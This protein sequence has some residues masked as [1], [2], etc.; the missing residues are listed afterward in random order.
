MQQLLQ[1]V[2]EVC[3]LASR[4]GTPVG[5]AEATDGSRT[6]T[7]RRRCSCWR[8]ARWESRRRSATRTSTTRSSTV[9]C[10]PPWVFSL[11]FILAPRAGASAAERPRGAVSQHLRAADRAAAVGGQ[12]AGLARR[13]RHLHPALLAL[14]VAAAPGGAPQQRTGAVA[15]AGRQLAADARGHQSRAPRAAAAAARRAARAGRLDTVPAADAAVAAVDGDVAGTQGEGAADGADAAGLPGAA[16]QGGVGAA[17]AAPA[18]AERRDAVAV[19]AVAAAQ[20]G[21]G[22]RE[23][24]GAAGDC[25]GDDQAAGPDGCQRPAGA[26]GGAAR[27]PGEPQGGGDQDGAGDGP[28][29]D[30]GD[31]AAN[32]DVR[33]AAAGDGRAGERAAEGPSLHGA[34]DALGERDAGGQALLVALGDDEGDG[35]G[36]SGGGGGS[37]EG[38]ERRASVRHVEQEVQR[39]VGSRVFGEYVADSGVGV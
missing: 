26:T 19:G 11:R 39:R 12:P 14:A 9:C 37:P 7:A 16:V 24:E 28:Q 20:G 2:S 15:G 10:R 1:A 33:L 32:T 25:E 13:R 35:R 21:G 6:S 30:G 4:R 27:G 17:T 38:D 8:R 36:V 22:A 31:D 18:A 23:D 3:S 5:V 34:E 29:R